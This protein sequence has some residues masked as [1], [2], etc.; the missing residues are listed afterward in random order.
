MCSRGLH[1]VL[2]GQ[3]LTTAKNW[4]TIVTRVVVGKPSYPLHELEDR[5]QVGFDYAGQRDLY[6]F[7]GDGHGS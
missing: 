1:H 7:F 2:H 3:S 6:G 4:N 5:Q